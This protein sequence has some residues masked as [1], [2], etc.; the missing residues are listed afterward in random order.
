MSKKKFPHELHPNL[1]KFNLINHF[2][3]KIARHIF[4]NVG[5]PSALLRPSKICNYQSI[6]LHYDTEN[7]IHTIEVCIPCLVLVGTRLDGTGGHFP[8]C[9]DLDETTYFWSCCSGKFGKNWERD[10]TT[11]YHSGSS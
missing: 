7:T 9:R 11:Q 10:G 4:L 6:N 1:I 8:N 3:L 2:V 5:S